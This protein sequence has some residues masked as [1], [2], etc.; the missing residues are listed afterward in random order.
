V[1]RF[2]IILEAELTKFANGLEVEF[3]ERARE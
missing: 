3:Q 2:E 1:V